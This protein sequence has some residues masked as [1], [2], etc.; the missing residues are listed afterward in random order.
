[1]LTIAAILFIT[2]DAYMQKLATAISHSAAKH[3]GKENAPQ[4]VLPQG[5]TAPNES[6]GFAEF[7]SAAA[8]AALWL[9]CSL[10]S[11]SALWWSVPAAHPALIVKLWLQL[12]L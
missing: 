8:A 5:Q 9:D 1:M 10:L 7:D 2:T 11:L 6:I 3:G 4:L 12:H